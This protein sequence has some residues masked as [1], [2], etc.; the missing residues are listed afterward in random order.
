ME[1][2]NIAL[3]GV[4]VVGQSTINVLRQNQADLARRIGREICLMGVA[5]KDP[6]K[7]RACDL[8]DVPFFDAHELVN[9][10]KVDIVVEL[11]GGIDLAKELLL[12]ALHANKHCVTANKA[13]IAQAGHELFKLAA[14]KDRMISFEASVAG[15]IPIIKSIRE[16]LQ[17]NQILS[18]KGIV[19]GTCNYI[20][21]KMRDESWSFEYALK[22]A[23]LLGFAEMDPTFDVEGIDSA[24][25]LAILASIAFGIPLQ[26]DL[27]HIKGIK[28]ICAMD[29]AMAQELGFEI[30][31]LAIAKRQSEGIELRVHPT[32]IKKK[33][34]LASVNG[35]M[36]AVLVD[37]NAVG[38]TMYYGAG[39]GGGPTASAVVADIVETAR[40]LSN[41]QVRVPYLAFPDAALA[42]TKILSLSDH[43]TGAYFRIQ[44][45]DEPGVLA[46]ITELLSKQNISIKSLIQKDPTVSKDNHVTVILLTHPAC[47]HQLMQAKDDIERLDSTYQSISFLPI[48]PIEDQ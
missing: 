42:Q 29:V 30:K 28:D 46:S 19:N 13:L 39:A 16:G 25:K 47:W 5:V 1:P 4:G 27:I 43:H 37:A 21:T 45:A 23:Q 44:V 2:V 17:G 48:E 6:N 22:Q 40:M 3:L 9:H 35:A 36:N 32:L 24:H 33:S 7:H 15:G 38:P 18:C 31:L 20:L 11:M 14:S 10:P 34:M 41:P 26:F 8:A 12:E